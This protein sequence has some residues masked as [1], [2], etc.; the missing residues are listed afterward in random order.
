M[1]YA[2]LERT[3]DR[4]TPPSNSDRNTNSVMGAFIFPILTSSLMLAEIGSYFAGFADEWSS[5]HKFHPTQT[6]ARPPD[7]ID[8]SESKIKSE[9]RAE[10]L[11]Y[12]D[13]PDDWDGD[14]GHAPDRADIENAVRFMEQ[15]HP[16]ALLYAELMV[17]GDGDVGFDWNTKTGEIEVGFRRGNVSFY[18]KTATGEEFRGDEKF[19]GNVPEKLRALINAVF[20]F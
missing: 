3:A 15:V 14:G 2:L 4:F 12:A 19:D 1:N 16:N 18:G 17:A 13:M 11:G 10:L 8:F 9:L 5:V 7:I 20:P 6:V